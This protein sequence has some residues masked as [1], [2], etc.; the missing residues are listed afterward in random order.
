[1]D[2]RGVPAH[3][4]AFHG[5]PRAPRMYVIDPRFREQFMSAHPTALYRR[6]VESVPPTFCGTMEQLRPLVEL[7][8]GQMVKAFQE[9][10]MAIPPWRQDIAQLSKWRPGR[11]LSV[12]PGA[13][14]PT[15]SDSGALTEN[16]NAFL[17]AGATAR[18]PGATSSLTRLRLQSEGVN[19]PR[20]IE[21]G[22]SV[23]SRAGLVGR[24]DGMS[25]TDQDLVRGGELEMLC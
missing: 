7:L 18:V 5:I 19:T 16:L 6:L 14:T 2:G 3:S 9:Q 1:M 25:D 24:G 13:L 21:K 11:L 15:G 8:A 22:F 17:S 23:H 12:S 10:D 4:P 20:S